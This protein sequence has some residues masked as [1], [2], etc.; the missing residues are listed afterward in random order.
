[1]PCSMLS[2]THARPGLMGGGVSSVNARKRSRSPSLCLPTL[3]P[4]KTHSSIQQH[5]AFTPPIPP[6]A[7]PVSGSEPS[8][9]ASRSPPPDVSAA[10]PRPLS[11]TPT[12]SL[13]QSTRLPVVPARQASPP[14]PKSTSTAPAVEAGPSEESCEVGE[15]L[16]SGAPPSSEAGSIKRA[17]RTETDNTA[18]PATQSTN[19]LP[20]KK[21][22]GPSEA[23][24]KDASPMQ[25][26]QEQQ[27]S[28]MRA[29][30]C[31]RC[32]MLA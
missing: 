18:H 14:S 7:A 25:G 1:V 9:V 6:T 8:S 10:V 12:V 5:K 31:K 29:P 26:V 2:P 32:H 20:Q 24:S 3:P 30:P 27:A 4:R 23:S 13:Q 19:D 28:M 17:R 15:A 16:S 11:P 22:A 21:I